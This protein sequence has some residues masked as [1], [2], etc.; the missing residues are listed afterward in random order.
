M[1][2]KNRGPKN[3]SRRDF[4]KTSAAGF[5]AVALTGL[6]ASQT[7]A[8]AQTIK[9]DREADVLVVGSGATGLPAAIAAIEGGASVLVI[10]ANWDVGGHAILSGGNVALGGG[11]SK[12]KQYE[13]V[14]SPD[15]LF[16]DLTDWSVVE[17]NGFPDYRYNDKEIIR[18]F[19][20]NSAPTFEWLVAHGVVFVDKAPD[21]QGAGATGNSAPRE[22]HA[23]AMAWPQMQTGRPVAAERQATSSSGIGL[24]RPLEASARKMGAQILLQHRMAGLIRE[25]PT[26]GRIIGITATSQ[27]K[28]VNIRAKKGVILATGGSTGNVNFR[29]MFDPRLTEEYCG[30]AGE[31]YTV[32]DASGELAGIAIGASLWGLYNQTGEFGASITKPGRIGCQYGYV[33]LPWQPTSP[34]FKLARAIGLR[35]TDWQDV[36][37]VNQAGVRFYDE[38]VGQFTSNNY[39]AIK[40]Y[41]PRSYLNAANIK[42]N[43]RNFLN[44]AIAGTGEAVNG[45]GPIWAIFDSDA[46]KR[47]NWTVAPPHVDIAEGFFAAAETIAELASNIKNKYQKKPMPADVLEKTVTNYNSFVDA[48]KDA[49][50]GKP[51]PKYKIQTPPFYAGWATP[52]LHDT[53]AGLRINA[54]CQ[55]MDFSGNV[56]PGLYCGGE[57]A[58]GFSLHGLARCT[59][60]GRIA[61]K[62]AALEAVAEISRS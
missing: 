12:Q 22:N 42:Y 29:R 51:A 16:S 25:H 53:R 61:G 19:A 7:S 35:I 18:A 44:A 17:S 60:Q 21:N 27:G 6:G 37:L 34:I 57:S 4:L 55:V 52:V 5:G 14:D 8:Q 38:T 15:L 28:T 33:N 41:T 49:D 46:V 56:I 36:I 62:N 45:G 26:S 31:P 10:E 11:T 48:G 39:N 47:E 30:V 40:N 50:F 2:L 3:F 54:K 58:G 9:W 13:V 32:Q 1:K 20:D 43:P 59:V 24:I 23:A